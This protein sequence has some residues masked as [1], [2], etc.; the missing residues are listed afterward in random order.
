[1]LKSVFGFAEH[2]EKCTYGLGFKVILTKNSDSSVLKKANATN[3]AK[4]KI[5]G[6][7]WYVTQYIPSMEQ[8]KVIS[9]QFL[10][11]TPTELQYVERST[12]RKKG[13]LETFGLLTWGLKKE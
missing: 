1:M 3:I 9:E 4:I 6:I 10:S 12:F 13:M 11:K 7:D 8:L 2:Q 5:I